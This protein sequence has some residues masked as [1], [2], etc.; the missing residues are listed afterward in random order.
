M[1]AVGLILGG[2]AGVFG[3]SLVFKARDVEDEA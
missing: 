1:L 3:M 2:I